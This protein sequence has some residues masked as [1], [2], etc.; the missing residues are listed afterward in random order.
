MMQKAG[1]GSA[2]VVIERYGK[3]VVAMI[4]YEDFVSLQGELDDLRAARRAAEAYQ[5]WKE[6]PGRG[7]PWEEVEAELVNEGLLDA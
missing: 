3:P 4:A 6:Q 5:A 2:D 1:S 7:R